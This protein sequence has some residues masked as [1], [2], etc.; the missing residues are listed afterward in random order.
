MANEN[1]ETEMKNLKTKIQDNKVIIGKEKV[2]KQLK[3]KALNKIYLA[4]NCPKELRSD[5]AHYAKLVGTA[6]VE[7]DL[8][9]EELGLFCRKNFFIAVLAT[10]E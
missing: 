4:S 6:V 8:N 2:L 7:L 10:T 5:I 9:N 1:L 3:A